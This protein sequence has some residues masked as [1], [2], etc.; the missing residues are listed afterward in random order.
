[1]SARKECRVST[2]S[3]S[4]KSGRTSSAWV[5]L[6]SCGSDRPT[7]RLGRPLLRARSVT[8]NAVAVVTRTAS[9]ATRPPTSANTAC[10]RSRD[11]GRHSMTTPADSMPSSESPTSTPARSAAAFA[12]VSSRSTPITVQPAS[13]AN[14]ATCVPTVPTPTIATVFSAMPPSLAKRASATIGGCGTPD[15]WTTRTSMLSSPWSTNA[16]RPTATR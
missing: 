8:D 14:P 4:A 3:E 15:R 9:G 13:R 11:S 6:G 12:V 7:T 10:L 16:N 5:R 1:M 2:A